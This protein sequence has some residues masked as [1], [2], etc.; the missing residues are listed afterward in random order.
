MRSIL[1]V[2]ITCN[3]SFINYFI[4]FILFFTIVAR[5]VL[6]HY[7]AVCTTY[8]NLGR[9]VWEFTVVLPTRVLILDLGQRYHN[10]LRVFMIAV[11]ALVLS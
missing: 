6:K 1:L 11:N 10:G 4:M 9:D 8:D 2:T 3:T 7:K 5:V